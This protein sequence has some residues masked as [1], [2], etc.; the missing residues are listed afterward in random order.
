MSQ[1]RRLRMHCELNRWLVVLSFCALACVGCAGDAT[2]NA[3]LDSLEG[4]VDA[5]GVA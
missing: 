2:D 1:E 4:A 3:R 5:R